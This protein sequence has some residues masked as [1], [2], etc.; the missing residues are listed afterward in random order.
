[1][2]TSMATV[3]KNT[4]LTAGIPVIIGRSIEKT[5]NSQGILSKI[6]PM[7]PGGGPP[8]GGGGPKM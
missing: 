6:F 1:M 2:T 8:G 5:E 4:S 3:I 7:S